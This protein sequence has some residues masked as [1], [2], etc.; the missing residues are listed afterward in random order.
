MTRVTV[1]NES[2]YVFVAAASAMPLSFGWHGR[3]STRRAVISTSSPVLGLQPG[4]WGFGLAQLEITETGNF[5]FFTT[6]QSAADFFKKL[7]DF[8]WHH[9]W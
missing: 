9:S 2:F 4:R 5:N 7:D 3:F 6:R 1:G 8:L